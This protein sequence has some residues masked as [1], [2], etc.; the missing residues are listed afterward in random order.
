[1]A[2]RFKK[3][4]LI[5]CSGLFLSSCVSMKQYRESQDSLYQSNQQ[6]QS[7]KQD[8]S[9]V[10]G[11]LQLMEEANQAAAGRMNTQDSNLLENQKQLADQKLQLS[12]QQQNLLA[13]QQL[14][15]RQKQQTEALREKISKALGN[16]NAEDLS[17][18]K[19]N[20]KVYVRMSEKLLFP[21]GSA[22]VNQKGID[23]L[24]KL[25]TALNQNPDI[26]ID[27]E[28]HTDTVPI[29]IKYP[30]NWAL[31]TARATAIVRILIN[32][33]HVN[34]ERLTASGRSQYDPV[35]DNSTAEGR[36]KN[37][38]TEIILAPK[39]S[40]LMQIMQEEDS[41]GNSK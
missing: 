29:K 13:L 1:M 12:K 39:L 25:A 31:S 10:K 5:T 33:Y 14:I 21:S 4:A 20:G 3:I 36:A 2:I 41:S 35:A 8:L 30:D 28:G 9:D 24:G 15:D 32:E 22:V 26:D 27:I 16:F 37:R 7:L 38:R 18:Y 6:N 19:K 11:R 34:P 23:A 40:Q 17:V